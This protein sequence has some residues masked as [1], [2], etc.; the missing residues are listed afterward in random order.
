[1]AFFHETANTIFKKSAL[2]IPINLTA[3]AWAKKYIMLFSEDSI[4][5]QPAE[6]KISIFGTKR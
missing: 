6:T 3:L 1:M 5:Q 4:N 2:H